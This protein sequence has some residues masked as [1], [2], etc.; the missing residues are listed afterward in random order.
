ME[1]ETDWSQISRSDQRSHIK[2]ETLRGKN[3]TEIHTALHKVC[4]DSVVDCSTVGISF[5]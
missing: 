5:P 1:Q 3:P 4:G 2:I